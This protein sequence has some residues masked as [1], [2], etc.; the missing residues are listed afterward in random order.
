MILAQIKHA[1]RKSSEP[2]L[3]S[4]NVHAAL[5]VLST[6]SVMNVHP[7][8]DEKV[9]NQINAINASVR[10]DAKECVRG[11]CSDFPIEID[12]PRMYQEHIIL[13]CGCNARCLEGRTGR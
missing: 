3:Y 13:E 10:P 9:N 8:S 2:N 12:K 11:I 4:L 7:A 1:S 6:E 5:N